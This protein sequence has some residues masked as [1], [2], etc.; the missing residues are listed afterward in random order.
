MTS[1]AAP[2]R[3]A[4]EPERLEAL[5]RYEILDTPP[6][7]AF[8]D[9]ALL[10]SQVC[11]T[12]TALVSLVEGDRQWF[13]ARVRFDALETPRDVAFCAHAILGRDVFVVPDA[14]ADRRFADNP[15]V[16]GEPKIR[17]YA[18]APLVT[19][20]GYALGTLCVMDREPRQL[21]PGQAEA[22]EALS[23]QVVAQLELRRRMARDREE[24]GEALHDKEEALRVV[25]S[26]MPI[27]FWTMDRELRFTE[28]LGA[29]R[30]VLAE[31][32][33]GVLGQS[34]FAYFKTTDPEYPPIAAHRRAL[35]GESTTYEITWQGRTF[36][37]HVEPHRE[38][39]GTIRGVLGVAFDITER[40]KA[41]EELH[42]SVALL[43]ATIDATTDAILV[44]DA[45]GRMVNF[46]SRFVDLWGIPASVVESRDESQA[47]AS[48]L[49]KL[50]DPAAFVKK[51]M[52]VYAQPASGSHD[53]IEMKDGR[54]IE[55]DSLPQI[56][57][58][59]T[60]GRVWSFR[61][62]TQRLR[63]EEDVERTLSLLKA[64][65][66][67]TAD[68]ILVVDSEGAI[69]SYNRKFAEMWR[70]PEDVLASR[71][72]REALAF[73]LNQLRDPE[74]FVK[75]IQD[76]YSE[77][78]AKSY[79]WLDFKDGR[80]FER[81][82]A[83]QKVAGKTVGRVWSFHDV[84]RM[85]L[86][87]DTI[88]RHTRAFDHISDAVL[89]LDLEARIVDWNPGAEKM[90]GY[91]KADMLGKTPDLLRPA[92]ATRTAQDLLSAMRRDGRWSGEARFVR[93]DGG[94]G[95]C[96]IVVVP[97]FDDFGRVLAA[98][99]VCRDVTD[100]KSLE[101]YRRRETSP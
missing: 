30:A 77:P 2:P 48:V 94:K 1:S 25:L 73:V 91:A 15:M 34:L 41:E 22:L 38:T 88:R 85:R 3:P 16:T 93:K 9:L 54:R 53:L 7:A 18:G 19:S 11:G 26:Q 10:A 49:E 79:D 37:A 5:R 36:Q 31:R 51:V 74:R 43:E 33:E 8:D 35:E 70:I 67:A 55:R 95:V 12:P 83:P 28:S 52:S 69:V 4:N 71:D 98:L 45:A 64:T 24:A 14:A 58:G 92:G 21:T 99:A 84:T 56:V 87:E 23:R 68:G 46:N 76:L 57:D 89:T 72:D 13:K 62:V 86:M 90:F 32:P 96:D 100:R 65:L 82:S 78:E 101:E 66:E 97:L 47:M 61:D 60:E 27:I 75:K 50:S 63:A 59:R 17:F 80:M 29:G 42:R 40:K 39:D 81:Y 44:V 20:G 6:E